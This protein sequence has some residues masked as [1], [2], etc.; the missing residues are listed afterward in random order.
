[1]T[2]GRDMFLQYSVYT[3]PATENTQRLE[4]SNTNSHDNLLTTEILHTH[5]APYLKAPPP[6]ERTEYRTTC[7]YT[8]IH[9]NGYTTKHQAL[10]ANNTVTYQ[11]SRLI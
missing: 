10:P 4:A 5:C 3:V 11:R 6:R 9:M 1:M 7:K 2:A 8:Y